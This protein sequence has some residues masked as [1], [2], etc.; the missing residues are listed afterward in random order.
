M[1]QLEL[2]SNITVHWRFPEC[3]SSSLF[4]ERYISCHNNYCSSLC[5]FWCVQ[6]M[7]ICLIVLE[8]TKPKGILAHQGPQIQHDFLLHHSPDFLCTNRAT[9]MITNCMTLAFAFHNF[10]AV[11]CFY[12]NKL[13]KHQWRVGYTIYYL[14]CFLKGCFQTLGID[15]ISSSWYPI[16]LAFFF[17]NLNIADYF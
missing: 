14:K 15:L 11:A 7:H 16:T 5:W 10:T 2:I 12:I 1:K 17:L 3:F 4:L 9:K 13:F 6:H 8:S